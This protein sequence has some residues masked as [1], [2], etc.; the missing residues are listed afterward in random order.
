MV[1]TYRDLI[2]AYREDEGRVFIESIKGSK[3]L[4]LYT[5]G[6]TLTSTIPGISVAGASPK[7]TLYTPALDAEY[8]VIGRT[9]SM[10]T[11]PV[12]P[13]GIPT[14]AII[15]RSTLNL[16]GIPYM[17]VNAGSY[18]EPKI[19]HM[20]L[21]SRC[22]GGLI[23]ECKGLPR[24]VAKKLLVEA[25]VLGTTLS[26]GFDVLIIGESIPGGTTTA[27]GILVGLGYSAWGLVS[28]SGSSNPHKLKERVVRE[29]L[30]RLKSN[31]IVDMIECLGD[32][33]H[34]VMAGIVKAA[35]SND[36][37]VVLAG[38]TQM[39]AVLAILKKMYDIK[40]SNNLIIGTTRWIIHDNSS[41]IV[42]LVSM[43]YNDVPIVA[44]NIDF[45]TSKYDGL[46]YYERGYVK[47]G[48]GAGGT[49][50]VAYAAEGVN[51]EDIINAIYDEYSRLLDLGGIHYD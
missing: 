47:E 5:I 1:V 32:P 26:R 14:P 46:K 22:V 4:A 25:E 16:T 34:V 40:L 35:L 15:T 13:E 29:G 10:N 51:I 37:K 23:N 31:G 19:P 3:A 49:A 41:D 21:P 44:I 28:S 20:T 38:G 24:G 8:L 12:T 42:K 43:I 11:I 36:V 18:I 33:V 17:V 27:L 45:T 50:I 30:L 7:A 6:S 9:R 48:V 2:F 39:A